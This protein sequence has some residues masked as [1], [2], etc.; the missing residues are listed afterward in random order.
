MFKV[1]VYICNWEP[2]KSLL[3]IMCKSTFVTKIRFEFSQ[4]M[5]RPVEVPGL[6]TTLLSVLVLMFTY[7]FPCKL[8]QMCVLKFWKTKK[9]ST[10]LECLILFDF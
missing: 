7:L 2:F 9:L 6:L 4:Y 10:L 5:A 8:E 1:V 3:I